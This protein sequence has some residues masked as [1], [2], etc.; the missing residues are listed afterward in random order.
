MGKDSEL[1]DILE[2]SGY[3]LKFKHYRHS[4]EVQ[5]TWDIAQ[6]FK[7]VSERP[8]VDDIRDTLVILAERKLEQAAQLLEDLNGFEYQGLTIVR[9]NQQAKPFTPGAV[10]GA[11]SVQVFLGDEL[12]GVAMSYC[13]LEDHFDYAEGRKEALK[14]ALKGMICS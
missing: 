6:V 8:H 12:I 9:Y 10:G 7:E 3:K 11:T 14:E 1:R 13:S 4:H 2:S 5:G